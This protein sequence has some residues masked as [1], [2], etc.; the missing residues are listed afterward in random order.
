MK[1]LIADPDRRFAG[2]A[3]RYFESRAHMAVHKTAAEEASATAEQWRPDLLVV[4]AELAEDGLL[5]RIYA[6]PDRPAV[7]LTGW[8]DRCDRV[9][10]AWQSGGDEL[11]MKPVL[12]TRDLQVA[13]VT[14]MENATIDTRGKTVAA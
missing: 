6:L 4:A 7:L 2:R 9:W 14:A 10:R 1:V 12:N 11:L 3:L 13:V 8:V 5:E